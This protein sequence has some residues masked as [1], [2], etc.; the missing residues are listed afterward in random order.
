[1]KITMDTAKTILNAIGQRHELNPA[2]ESFEFELGG[3]GIPLNSE[4]DYQLVATALDGLEAKGI[5]KHKIGRSGTL[6]ESFKCK[7]TIADKKKFEAE[8]QQSKSLPTA[9]GVSVKFDDNEGVLTYGNKRC[10][11]PPFKNE[12]YFCRAAFEYPVG[13][14][15]WYTGKH[16]PLITRELY[17][18]VR[19]NLVRSEIKNTDKQFAF[20][21]LMT[22]GL[23]GSGIIADEK[24]KKL[25]SGGTARYIY[26]GCSRS[27]DRNCK[28]GY[29]RE[30]EIIKQLIEQINGLELDNNFIM[31]KFNV[32]RERAKKFQ[33]QFYGI[34]PE[35]TKVEFDPRQYTSYVLTQGSTE[36]KRE[37]LGSVKSKIILQKKQISLE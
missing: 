23:C 22:C 33:Q 19:A 2:A 21:R 3:L 35:L 27:R 9:P 10:Q 11:L 13:S 7:I 8:Y 34:K 31:R 14:G 20:S 32:E 37:F 36:E 28:C 18:K 5:I 16:E 26:Y 24:F 25:A 1:M 12:H 30:E 29:V 15:N 17:E 4:N 6:Y